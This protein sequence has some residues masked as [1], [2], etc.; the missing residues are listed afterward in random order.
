MTPD[1]AAMALSQKIAVN[2]RCARQGTGPRTAKGKARSSQNALRHGLAV[3]LLTTEAIDRDVRRL[4][5]AIAGP[6]PDPCRWHFAKIAAEAEQDLRRVRAV[7][8]SL[9]ATRAPAGSAASDAEHDTHPLAATL[10][11]LPRLDR[12]EH[13]ALSRR[14]RALRLL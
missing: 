3:T 8:L 14:N 11:N 9:L 12:Y 4:A 5:S 6:N 1:L 13:R 10:P 2:R 7:R